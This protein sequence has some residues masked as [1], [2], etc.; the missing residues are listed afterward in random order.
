[1][2]Y[3]VK[4]T[5][6]IRIEPGTFAALE[7]LAARVDI[8]WRGRGNVSGL[9]DRLRERYEADPDA[10]VALLCLRSRGKMADIT[11]EAE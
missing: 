10:T 6:T 5:H 2:E 7:R 4:T 3:A 1:M 8:T 11:K 9:L